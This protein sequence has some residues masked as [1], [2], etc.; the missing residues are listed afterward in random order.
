MNSKHRQAYA[1][2]WLACATSDAVSARDIRIDAV[3][4]PG[5]EARS[6]GSVDHFDCEFMS[7]DPRI[8][9]ERMLAFEY[10][11]VGPADSD[12][13]WAYENPVSIHSPNRLLN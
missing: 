6:C 2:V 5:L 10:V 7:H 12:T 13:P 11:I 1:A 9:Q 4:A 3:K 8:L